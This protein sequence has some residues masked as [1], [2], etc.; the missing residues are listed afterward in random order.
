MGVAW[1]ENMS[2]VANRE[3]RVAQEDFGSVLWHASK[4][5]GLD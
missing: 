2:D 4:L 3:R 5:L 1:R